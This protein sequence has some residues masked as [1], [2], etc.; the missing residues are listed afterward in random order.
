L[1]VA[2]CGGIKCSDAKDMAFLLKAKGYKD[3][4]LYSGG[5]E[6]WTQKNMPVEREGGVD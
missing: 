4:I 3:V 5:W 6:E 2:Y 1:N